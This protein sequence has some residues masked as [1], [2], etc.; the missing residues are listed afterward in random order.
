ML[1]DVVVVSDYAYVA[2][3]A[4]K[5]AIQS[6]VGLSGIG[7][8]VHYLAAIGPICAELQDV[9]NLNVHCM[10]QSKVKDADSKVK[11]A[12]KL[13][14]N[15][16]AAAKMRQ[17]LEPLSQE[18]TVVHFHSFLGGLSASAV[19]EASRQGFKCLYTLHDY[20]LACPQ[21]SFFDVGKGKICELKP[22]SLACCM[23]ACTGR[24]IAFKGAVTMRAMSN[25]RHRVAECFSAF[26]TLSD[27]SASVM[28]PYLPERP[29]QRVLNPIDAE[30]LGI[31]E[32][33]PGAPYLFVGR[34]TVE[35]DAETFLRACRKIGAKARLVGDGADMQRLA[36]EYPEAEYMGWANSGGVRKAMRESRALVFPSIWYEASPLTPYEA[37][38]N[39]LPVVCA[40]VNAAAET[41]RR[42]ENGLIFRA[43][44]ADDLAEK[45]TTMNDDQACAKFGEE[46]YRRY[47]AQPMTLDRHVD[48][49]I[50]VYRQALK[51]EN[52]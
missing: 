23:R 19:L 6:A 11:A 14:N 36:A 50:E 32:L 40:D 30:D 31:R 8:R 5:V 33:L 17:I 43:G 47:W 7:L 9:P 38:A 52:R 46:G 13:I 2:G 29:R 44:N 45:L 37:A 27:L 48:A 49:L 22:L 25:R 1:T 26:V 41:V 34:L 10:E 3:G 20:G 35:K 42:L 15:P 18:T 51:E 16:D 39:G 21:Q 4:E 28:Q 24:G 12:L